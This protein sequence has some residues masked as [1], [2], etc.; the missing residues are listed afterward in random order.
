MADNDDSSKIFDDLSSRITNIIIGRNEENRCA[1]SQILDDLNSL[2]FRY[3]LA[4]NP[5]KAQLLINQCCNFFSTDDDFLVQKCG[6]LLWN[7]VHLQNIPIE[8]TTLTLAINWCLGALNSRNKNVILIVL[9]ALNALLRTNVDQAL[10]LTDKVSVKLI[11]IIKGAEKI[12][13]PE[14]LWTALKCLEACTFPSSDRYRYPN[15]ENYAQIFI[16]YL[17]QD[18]IIEDIIH[19]KIVLVCLNGLQ[20]IVA[21]CPRYLKQELGPVL[22]IVKTFMVFGMKGIDYIPPKKLTPSPLGIPETSNI[23]DK[24]KKGGKLP[25]QRKQR[26]IGPKKDKEKSNDELIMDTAISGYRPATMASDFNADNGINLITSAIQLVNSDSDYSDSEAGICNKLNRLKSKIRQ[27]ACQLFYDVIKNTEKHTM[28]SYWTSFIPDGTASGSHNLLVCILKD[29]STQCKL[30][31]LNVLL[32]L[33]ASSKLYLFQAENSDKSMSFTPYS[34][35]LG[36][37]IKE[38]H[39]TLCFALME[40]SSPVLTQILKCLAA[41]V[42]ATPYHK[43]PRGLITKI[44]RNVKPFIYHKDAQVQVTAL[45][46]LGCVSASEPLVSETKDMLLKKNIRSN[47]TVQDTDTEERKEENGDIDFA[48]FSDSDNEEDTDSESAPW[49]IKACLNNLGVKFEGEESTCEEHKIPVPVPIKLESLQVLSSASRNYCDVL[50]VPYISHIT[51]GLYSTVSDKSMDLRFHAGRAIDF[52]G[53]AIGRYITDRATKDVVPLENFV[54]FWLTLLEGELIDLLQSDDHPMLK[55]VACD[56]I[57]SIGSDIFEQLPR[58]KQLLCITVL[59]SCTRDDQH[60]VRAA[61]IRALGVCVTFTILRQDTG[62]VVD[63]AEALSRTLNDIQLIV[64]I[65][66]S[67][68]LGNFTDALVLNYNSG[69]YLEDIPEDFILNLLRIAMACSKDNDK[70]KMNAVRALG[71]LI[72]V[73][74]VCLF[75]DPDFAPFID[76]AFNTLVQNSVKGPSMKVRWNACYAIGN[77]LKNPHLYRNDNLLRKNWQVS[78][79]NSLNELVVG[80]SNFKVRINAAL[81]LSCVSKRE[82]YGDFYLHIWMSLLLSL[83]NSQNLED[84]NEYKHRDNLV[85][86]VCLTLGHLTTILER[87]DLALLMDVVDPY[88]DAYKLHTRK[89]L[90]RLIP[91]KSKVL[92]AAALALNRLS[93]KSD[94]SPSEKQILDCLKTVYE[95]IV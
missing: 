18:T 66:A 5:I 73:S 30:A 75:H 63:T 70:M 12:W 61:A 43:M 65:K 83:E 94:L 56:C 84:F 89:V 74:N 38:L 59:F 37:M 60:N 58:H 72:Q 33:L 36:L 57:G 92:T 95:P 29:P 6:K 32:L 78:V 11:K 49:L 28:F 55:A 86:Q 46:V 25:K 87:R 27:A 21:Q 91:E 51:K 16:S 88:L 23:I 1:I 81:A 62:F 52:I 39:K 9:Q 90:D 76:E 79:F 69:E 93:A 54:K 2:D 44:M 40:N 50:I 82:Y 19:L 64:R 26:C 10:L 80:F 68:A 53:Q 4:I 45:I 20:N 3:S 24:G 13:S 14:L 48:Q 77:A 34:V 67:W 17:I 71:N 85:E 8:G 22:G 41:L 47:E 31:A 35:T 7:I 15:L 42:Q